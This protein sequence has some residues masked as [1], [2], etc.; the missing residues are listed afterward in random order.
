[1]N[2]PSVFNGPEVSMHRDMIHD[3]YVKDH[4]L[5]SN[6]PD[7]NFT[8]SL[9]LPLPPILVDGNIVQCIRSTE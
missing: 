2:E 7:H 6:F 8:L 4:P 9:I 5:R 1:M 3:K